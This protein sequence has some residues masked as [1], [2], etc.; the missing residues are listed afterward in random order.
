MRHIKPPGAATWRAAGFKYRD[1]MAKPSGF[2]RS[3]AACP[4]GAYDGSFYSCFH[5]SLCPYLL[6]FSAKLLEICVI[7]AK[8]GIQYP[9]LLDILWIPA[10]AGMTDTFAGMTDT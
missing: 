1:L 4:A 7:P 2:N 6:G 10:F 8:A 3:S 9:H 5:S